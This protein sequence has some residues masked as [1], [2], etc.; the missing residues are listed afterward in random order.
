MHF[1]GIAFVIVLIDFN[2]NLAV[3]EAIVVKAK[4][5]KACSRVR[6]QDSP[7]FVLTMLIAAGQSVFIKVQCI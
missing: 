7:I 3:L 5:V 4:L 2:C 1:P 6:V